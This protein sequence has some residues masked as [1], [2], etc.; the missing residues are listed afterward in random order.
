M[1]FHVG[2]HSLRVV[3]LDMIPGIGEP[4]GRSGTSGVVAVVKLGERIVYGVSRTRYTWRMLFRI[5]HP[6]IPEGLE[7][8]CIQRDILSREVDDL[9]SIQILHGA[10]L[11]GRPSEEYRIVLGESVGA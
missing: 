5:V 3:V 11:V 7:P 9:R 8:H 6:F 10:S 1:P 2:H 4:D